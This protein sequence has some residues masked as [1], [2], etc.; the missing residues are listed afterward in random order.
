MLASELSGRRKL[1]YIVIGALG[2]IV[3]GW[4]GSFLDPLTTPYHS[5]TTDII[6]AV[7]GASTFIFLTNLAADKLSQ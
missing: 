3:G 6:F 7:F 4:S 5:S 2:G 1:A